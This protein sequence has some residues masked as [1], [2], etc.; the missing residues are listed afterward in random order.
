VD[1]G[2]GDALVR[3]VVVLEQQLVGDGVREAGQLGCA[4]GALQRAGVDPGEG[5]GMQALAELPGPGFA[6]GREGDVGAAGVAAVLRPLGFA[7]P[8]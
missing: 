2:A 4:A 5:E 8:G 7:V 3:A 6:G 1:L